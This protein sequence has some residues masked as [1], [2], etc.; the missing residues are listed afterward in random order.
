MADRSSDAVH[1]AARNLLAAYRRLM[2]E[3]DEHLPIDPGDYDPSAF[4]WYDHCSADLRSLGFTSVGDTKSASVPAAPGSRGA[5]FV[6]R[7]ICADRQHRADLMELAGAPGKDPV[8]AINLVTE[9]SDGRYLVTTTGAQRWASP[10]HVIG[11]HLPGT[12]P[13][14]ALWRRHEQ[15]ARDYVAAHPQATPVRFASLADVLACEAR[16]RV[17]TARFRRR[18]AVPSVEE[19]LRLGSER[20]AA[21]AI[22]TEMRRLAGDGESEQAPRDAAP[23][24]A[25]QVVAADLPVPAGPPLTYL[26]L[27]HFALDQGARQVLEGGAPLAPFLLLDSGRAF[28]FVRG[29]ANADADPM[30]IAL[31]TL[32][33]HGGDARACALVLDTRLEVRGTRTEAIVVM[34]CER[35]GGNGQTWAQGYGRKGLLRRWALTS[36]RERVAECRNLFSGAQAS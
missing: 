7:L 12:T 30:A 27:I 24:A 20:D 3:T 26:A 22:H 28:F 17:L 1:K 9:F 18:Q 11:E 36:L 19:L 32:R 6:R 14:A 8:R 29:D 13:V 35:D 4:A 16:S 34:A 33:A 25:W 21:M 10:D 2:V 15:R 5:P 23:G 31:R